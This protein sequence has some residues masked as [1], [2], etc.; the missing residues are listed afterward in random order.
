MVG[1][2]CR[3]ETTYR[4]RFFVS[5]EREQ[6]HIADDRSMHRK[7]RIERAQP[8]CPFEGLQTAFRLAA[9][10]KRI[11]EPRVSKGKTGTELDRPRKMPDGFLRSPLPGMAQSENQMAPVLAVIERQCLRTGIERLVG[12]FV[13]R[14]ARIQITHAHKG[15]SQQSMNLRMQTFAIE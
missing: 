15:P 1:V 5:P 8:L 14:L 11:A 6:R 12:Q 10:G 4:N 3:C 7:K 9:T 13:D 2:T